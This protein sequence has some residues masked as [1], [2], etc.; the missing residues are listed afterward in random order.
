MR[1][2]LVAIIS[3]KLPELQF[4]GQTKDQNLVTLKLKVLLTLLVGEKLKV[5]F[6]RKSFYW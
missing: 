5:F 6:R 1:E 2:G 3:V 4:E